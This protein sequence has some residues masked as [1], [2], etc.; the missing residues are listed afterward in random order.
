MAD[1]DAV[2]PQRNQ[3]DVLTVDDH[4]AVLLQFDDVVEPA[5]GHRLGARRHARQPRR[6]EIHRLLK[7]QTQ[8]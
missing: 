4:L 1:V 7:G 2:D 5:D 8:C 6:R 3:V